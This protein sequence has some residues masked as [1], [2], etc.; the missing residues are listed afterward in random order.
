MHWGSIVSDDYVVVEAP[1]M[2]ALQREVADILRDNPHG[3]SLEATGGAG[4]REVKVGL[5]GEPSLIFWQ[6]LRRKGR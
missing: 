4:C 3:Y 1:D 2:P 5:S 6:S